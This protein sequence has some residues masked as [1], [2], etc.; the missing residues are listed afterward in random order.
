MKEEF[1]KHETYMRRCLQLAEFGRL[2]AA[3]NPMVGSVV[4]ACGT[5]IGEG[6]HRRCGEAHAEV[7][8]VNS[9]KNTELLKQSTLYV[10]LEPCAHIGRTPAC[11]T[12]II[13]KKI[14]RVVIGC[15]DTFSKVNGK[16]I[17]MLQNAGIEVIVGVLESES[18][19]LNRRFFTFH[20]KQRP[21]II[22]KW[23]QT[24]DGFID[25][26]RSPETLVGPNW[27]TDDYARTLVHKWRAEESAILV[28]TN[29]VEKDNPKL[30]VRDW[31]GKNPLR[32]VL[33]RTGR[34][35]RDLSVFDL[36]QQTLVFTENESYSIPNL[37]FETIEFGRNVI[38]NIVTVLYNRGLQSVI[39]EGGAIVLQ[40]FIDSGFW[41]EAR[42][43]TGLS[44]F[45]SGVKA[46]LLTN[47]PIK[48]SF[49]G[50]ALLSIYE[51]RA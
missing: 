15:T 36:T 19:I 46:P 35:S 5:I 40:Q 3:P 25:Y 33:D 18:R 42:V 38:K 14:P 11:S 4:V 27:I 7:N 28:G 34:L 6:W 22:L 43:F 9:V 13:Q 51:N 21:Y 1:I 24:A 49:I 45:V 47:R 32:V 10:N 17:E 2:H 20:E 23:A 31:S 48:E 26:E 50:N 30:N 16:G 44:R 37:S 8:A 29:T 39:V 12:M 41:D